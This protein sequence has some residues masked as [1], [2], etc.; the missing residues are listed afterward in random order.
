MS[1]SDIND[2]LRMEGE[3]TA[4]ARHDQSEKYKAKNIKANGRAHEQELGTGVTVND[5]HAY[6]PMHNYIFAPSRD[7]WPA[8][9]VNSRIPPIPTGENGKEKLM[10]ASAWLDQNRSV[11]QITWAPGLTDAYQEPPNIGRRMDR[12]RRRDMLQPLSAADD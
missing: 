10:P 11:E 6:M 3:A 5:F 8:S 2:T 1:F 4:L 9:S 12:A 7:M